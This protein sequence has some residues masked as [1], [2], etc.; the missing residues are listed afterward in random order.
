M[1]QQIRRPDKSL[2]F[3]AI[4]IHSNA[5]KINSTITAAEPTNPSS[6]PTIENMKSVC[7]SEI[8]LPFL[9]EDMLSLFNPFPHSCPEPIA[10]IEFC[11]WYACCG[12]CF[13]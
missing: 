11:C 2:A 8:K 3:L 12:Y 10:M 13:G 6:S 9:T 1:P 4:K 5:I 7:G